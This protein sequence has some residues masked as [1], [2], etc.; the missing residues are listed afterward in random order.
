MHDL[1]C[2]FQNEANTQS[3]LENEVG[4]LVNK[5]KLAEARLVQQKTKTDKIFSNISVAQRRIIVDRKI[6]TQLAAR[7]ATIGRDVKGESYK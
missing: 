5:L 6:S 3:I 2:Q 7:C 4:E 1:L